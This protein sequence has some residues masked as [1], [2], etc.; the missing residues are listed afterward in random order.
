MYYYISVYRRSRPVRAFKNTKSATSSNSRGN[1][2]TR[3]A[4]LA[5]LLDPRF[6]KDGVQSGQNAAQASM[7]LENELRSYPAKTNPVITLR[8]YTE[9]P[10][11]P[12][13]VDPLEYWKSMQIMACKYLCIPA[14]ESERMFSKAGE[15]VSDRRTRLKEK[16]VDM[17]LFINKSHEMC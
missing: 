16:N 12:L 13:D 7:L 4:R 8:E 3:L 2:V 9:K 11:E 6:K 17:L 1:R 10:N 5:T 14:T 15:L